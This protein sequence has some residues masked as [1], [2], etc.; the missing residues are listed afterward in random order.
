MA[1]TDACATTEAEDGEGMGELFDFDD[2][3]QM[4][5]RLPRL[6]ALHLGPGVLH[7]R[8]SC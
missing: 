7:T 8:F 1:Y 6:S 4:R 2:D 5:Q 3:E